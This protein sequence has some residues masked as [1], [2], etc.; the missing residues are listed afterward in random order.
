MANAPTSAHKGRPSSSALRRSGSLPRL[1]PLVHLVTLLAA[2]LAVVPSSTTAQA[3]AQRPEAVA[4]VV[5]SL[6]SYTRWPAEREKLRLCV[7]NS[8]RYADKLMEGGA[9]PTG[10]LV[11]ARRVDVLAEPTAASCDTVYLGTMTDARRKKLSGELT[12]RPVLVISEEDYECEAASMFCLTFRD[13]H[14]VAFRVNLDAI[15]R[16][17]IHIHPGVLQLGRRRGGLQ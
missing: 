5:F 1:R 8:S 12:G 6:L 10:R 4:R 7:D 11:E 16:S 2:T 13:Q 9:L 17:G 15:A 14:Q 3:G